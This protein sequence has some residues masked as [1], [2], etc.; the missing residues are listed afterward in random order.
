MNPAAPPLIDY[1]NK[2]LAEFVAGGMVTLYHGTQPGNA[3]RLLR[4][5]KDGLAPLGSN[6][7]QPHLLYAT[8]HPENA[9]WFAE[10][11]GGSDILTVSVP[12]N[13]LRVD[14]EDGVHDSVLEELR[15]SAKS[16][17]P[18]SLAVFGSLASSN[19]SVFGERLARA[20]EIP[21]STF[22]RN[23]F[24]D[25]RAPDGSLQKDNF[26]EWF[27]R[28]VCKNEADLPQVCYHGTTVWSR[29]DR[30]LGDI[31]A[32]DRMSSISRVRR[33]P[34]LDNVGSWFST[35]PG[36]NGAGMYA[37]GD[38][39]AIYPVFLR[40]LDP[41]VTTFDAMTR[42]ARALA[43]LVEDQHV[44]EAGVAALRYWLQETGR[45]GICIRHDEQSTSTEFKHQTAWIALEASQI[46]SAIGNCGTFDLLDPSISDVRAKEKAYLV[47][48]AGQRSSQALNF[49]SRI[50]SGP[51]NIP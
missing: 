6:L 23:R 32:F 38:S 48:L 3:E 26:A 18:A 17:V 14:P 34:S 47:T 31:D 21:L 27:G 35:N 22:L 10:Q 7:G 39:A 44:N 33:R 41:W 16:G 36:E 19:F 50:S 12:V 28:S 30:S 43:G 37:G 42:R 29:P 1:E 45:D 4:D 24:G 2:A 15:A 20:D 46:K 25:L 40:I 49:L 8:T 5:G 11:A 51:K 13:Q 9:K